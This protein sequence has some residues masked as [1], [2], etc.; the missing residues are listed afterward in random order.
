MPEPTVDWPATRS[1]AYCVNQLLSSVRLRLNNKHLSSC[2]NV[3]IWKSIVAARYE[4]YLLYTALKKCSIEVIHVTSQPGR[5]TAW[6]A[7]DGW[8]HCTAL[9]I[10]WQKAVLWRRNATV[11]IGTVLRGGQAP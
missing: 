7:K 5:L 10:Q 3:S 11:G 4:F 9:A 1:A 8:H 2:R 6:V